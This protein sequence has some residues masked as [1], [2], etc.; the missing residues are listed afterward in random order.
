LSRATSACTARAVSVRKVIAITR[1]CD[2]FFIRVFHGNEA[3]AK[4]IS[5]APP[6]KQRRRGLGFSWPP[7]QIVRQF[8]WLRQLKPAS[9]RERDT[10]A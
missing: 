2:E 1:E 5:R 4:A 6:K 10:P 8:R 9:S 3:Y 7:A